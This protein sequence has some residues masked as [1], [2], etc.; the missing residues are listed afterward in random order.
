MDIAAVWED[1]EPMAAVWLPAAA[2]CSHPFAFY[3][4]RAVQQ[5][6]EVAW[7]SPIWIDP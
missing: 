1:R 2:F 3:Y 5:D 4:V 6:G 7:A